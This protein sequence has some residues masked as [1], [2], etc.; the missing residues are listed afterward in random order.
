MERA[1]GI[2]L[3]IYALPS[4]HG[5][6]TL[7]QAAYDF[8]D[9][10]ESAGQAWWQILPVGPT[11]YGDSPYQSPSTFAGN[12]Y[13][14]DLDLLVADGLLKQAEVDAPDWGD[15]PAHVD[16][17]AL[18]EERMPLLARACERGWERD[19]AAVE[20]FSREQAS[21]LDDYALYM[22]IKRHFG[23]SSWIEW[24]DEAARL[25]EP[26]A[27]ERY[28][29][30]L[31]S[32]IRLETYV[33]YLFFTQWEALR[34][35]AREHGVRILGD[36]PIY[37]AL[38]SADVWANPQLFQLDEQGMPSA[39]AGVPPDS[40]TVDGQLWG[41]PLYDWD[42]H[43]AE[44]YG[45]WIR[46]IGGASRLYDMIRIDHF[47]GFES[48]WSVP[49]GSET[50]APGTWVKGPGA[51]LV[52]VLAGWFPDLD[53]IAEDLGYHTAGV[54]EL[55]RESG[56][57]GMKVL[58]FAFDSRD[59][60]G[61]DFLPHSYVRNCTC[62]V[63]THDN[64][65]VRAWFDEIDEDDRALVRDY[66]GI[67]AGDEIA[68]P[69]IRIGMMSVADLFVAQMQDYLELGE[70]SRTNTPGTLGGNWQWRMV[71]GQAMPEL[72][73]RIARMTRLYGRSAERTWQ[74]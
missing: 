20:A 27:L 68:W 1:S 43:E 30:E 72:A 64:A 19:A 63:G 50:A 61:A 33:Q 58:E 42:A 53:F 51:A 25:R 45:W 22:A 18:Y 10:L 55:L 11:S 62:Y 7:G 16:Y 39:V 35:Y 67:G 9:F 17:R 65:P 14:I 3:P 69:I 46:R 31:A 54:E 2:I 57:P 29:S 28:R 44:G 56:F 24:P 6:G 13:L 47:R 48:Y 40:F 12:P 73:A 71:E 8:V 26:D 52:K 21:W 5:V 60:G 66:L 41:N 37:V 36:L 74:K 38:D 15:D 32:D 59:D 49:A 4:P 34:A 70:G 23:M